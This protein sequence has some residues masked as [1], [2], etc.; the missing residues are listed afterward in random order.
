MRYAIVRRIPEAPGLEVP[1][2]PFARNL[3]LWLIVA[4]AILGLLHFVPISA[5]QREVVLGWLPMIGFVAAWFVVM[6]VTQRRYLK[7]YYAKADAVNERLH[8]ANEA[9]ITLLTEIRN[10]RATAAPTPAIERA[11]SPVPASQPKAA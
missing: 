6:G 1:L 9:I 8:A 3:I 2:T 4:L 5:D 7:D 10:Q 11:I